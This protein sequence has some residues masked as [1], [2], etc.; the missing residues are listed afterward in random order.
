MWGGQSLGFLVRWPLIG[1]IT[2]H[3]GEM[4]STRNQQGLSPFR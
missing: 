4:I 2:N 3:V 1:H